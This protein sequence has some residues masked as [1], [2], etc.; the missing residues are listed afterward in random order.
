LLVVENM[1]IDSCLSSGIHGG[2]VP[3]KR[4]QTKTDEAV[5]RILHSS[6]Q[7]WHLTAASSQAASP[8]QQ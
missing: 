5:A 3:D 6:S 4:L 1:A 2:N 8:F 7:E